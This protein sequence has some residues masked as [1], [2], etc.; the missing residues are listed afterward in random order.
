[1]VLNGG[2]AESIGNIEFTGIYLILIK[3]NLLVKLFVNKNRTN[4]SLNISHISF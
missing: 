2:W 3:A 4:K 1:M